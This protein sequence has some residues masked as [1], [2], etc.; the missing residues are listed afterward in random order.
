MH[1]QIVLKLKPLNKKSA[2]NWNADKVLTIINDYE[3]CGHIVNL[4]KKKRW[5]NYS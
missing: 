5:T 4:V 2:E 3:Y 1:L